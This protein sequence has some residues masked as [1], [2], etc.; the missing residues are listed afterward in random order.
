MNRQLIY[1]FILT[2]TIRKVKC[3]FLVM[4]ALAQTV[5]GNLK[6]MCFGGADFY[7]IIVLY[8]TFSYLGSKI[9]EYIG[10]T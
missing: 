1:I 10:N 2:Q 9:H 4:C 7:L 5:N 8:K 3:L 6:S